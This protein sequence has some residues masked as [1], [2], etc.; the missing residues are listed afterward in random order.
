MRRI[1]LTTT[2]IILSACN[3]AGTPQTVIESVTPEGDAQVFHF[4]NR[5]Q[6]FDLTLS[7]DWESIPV[8]NGDAL[9]G[10][11]KPRS[12]FGI[13]VYIPTLAEGAKPTEDPLWRRGVLTT[14]RDA[15]K[16]KAPAEY[17]WIGSEDI[18]LY[19]APALQTTVKQQDGS[20]VRDT[21]F[22]RGPYL[23]TASFVTEENGLEHVW[24]EI[25]TAMEG[26]EFL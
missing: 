10:R 25:Q 8:E 2:L 5:D 19:G 12:A 26:M 13:A 3:A 1:L 7:K 23:F 11:S 24:P 9:V 18:D 6:K 4:A 21:Y 15:L 22:L 17:E 20:F 16:A 14:I